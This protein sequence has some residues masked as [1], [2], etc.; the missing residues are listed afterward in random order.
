[1]TPPRLHGGRI[2][3]TA[4][5]S[6]AALRHTAAHGI[7]VHGSVQM[8][9]T[10]A[11]PPSVAMAQRTARQPIQGQAEPRIY[12]SQPPNGGSGPT[13][14][15]GPHLHHQQHQLHRPQQVQQQPV[16]QFNMPGLR[17]H[18]VNSR[19][20]LMKSHGQFGGS[21]SSAAVQPRRRRPRERDEDADYSG[22]EIIDP[23]R[24]YTSDKLEIL[25][26]AI[27]NIHSRMHR[28]HQVPQQCEKI[29][30]MFD[31]AQ[32]FSKSECTSP[33]EV[34]Q[35]ILNMFRDGFFEPSELVGS[36]VLLE[37]MERSIGYTFHKSC[38]RPLLIVALLVTDKLLQDKA[39]K[40][41]SMPQLCP[42]ISKEK[43][44]LLEREFVVTILDHRIFIGRHEWKDMVK[45]MFVGQTL[46]QDIVREVKAHQYV[47]S[48]TFTGI[49]KSEGVAHPGPAQL[50]HQ[51]PVHSNG[52]VRYN[53]RTTCNQRD[54]AEG[55]KAERG[56]VPTIRTGA[57]PRRPGFSDNLLAAK[58]PESAAAR[59]Q[60]AV[61]GNARALSNPE[62]QA[63]RRDALKVD[64]EPSLSS[65]ASC[66][67][68]G[69][70]SSRTTAPGSGSS[71]VTTR[72]GS[73]G[74]STSGAALPNAGTVRTQ[75]AAFEGSQQNQSPRA[76]NSASSPAGQTP[77]FAP[78]LCNS[79]SRQLAPHQV[80]SRT[81]VS[82]R[83]D[84]SCLTF[85]QKQ[86]RFE[87]PAGPQTNEKDR[88]RSEP[89][90]TRASQMARGPQIASISS[91]LHQAV[92]ADQRAAVMRKTIPQQRQPC[93][94]PT[95]LGGAQQ[96]VRVQ[97][98]AGNVVMNQ[99][100][101]AY[102]TAA[103]PMLNAGRCRSSSPTYGIPMGCQ[104]A[105]PGTVQNRVVL[106]A[107][108]GYP[109]R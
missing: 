56:Q 81:A 88:A 90:V 108:A 103:N 97:S 60:C 80:Q 19:P 86:Q 84:P 83:D 49:D 82:P 66:C 23:Q 89:T 21:S 28:S 10:Y 17:T 64:A 105:P 31:E 37:R 73:D 55:A 65:A 71:G 95:T 14:S 8:P 26:L 18:Q 102:P 12:H 109:F 22:E 77:S 96:Q 46:H 76:A 1:M 2:A 92:S 59:H 24:D 98:T 13:M 41:E 69:S 68:G 44:A 58:A 101:A 3:G 75:V 29:A 51:A 48:P 94:C 6:P 91:C 78:S 79:R 7:P 52:A 35:W 74:S 27:S 9:G 20:D 5:M 70:S 36:I 54:N 53:P 100:A 63:R 104:Q 38:W 43:L 33:S 11:T 16:Q 30:R 47:R 93:P 67:L 39:V 85:E 72:T 25:C 32:F 107:P 40:N 34:T 45:K 99:H 15:A 87:V 62:L 61:L 42:Q 4:S 106:Q 50:G 57:S